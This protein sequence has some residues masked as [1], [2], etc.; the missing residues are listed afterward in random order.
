[1]VIVANAFFNSADNEGMQPLSGA[2]VKTS[3]ELKSETRVMP[4]SIV[5]TVVPVG[6]G[7]VVKDEGGRSFT[8]AVL[9]LKVRVR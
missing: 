3:N 6:L 9:Q 4:Y 5:S 2:A 1:L 8:G 7:T